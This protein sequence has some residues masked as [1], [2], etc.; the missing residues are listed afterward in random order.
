MEQD[1][2]PSLYVNEHSFHGQFASREDTIAAIHRLW[3][4]NRVCREYSAQCL[5]S[6]E[7]LGL[8]SALSDTTLREVVV[9]YPNPD[10]RKLVL[11]WLDKH[12]PF[13]DAN[14]RH[15]ADDWYFA[16]HGSEELLATGSALAECARQVLA[17]ENAAL[18]SAT[19]SDFTYTPVQAGILNDDGTRD[20]CELSNHWSEPPLR[21]Y[22]EN[23]IRL[24]SWLELRDHAKQRFANLVF[25]AD[26]FEPMMKSPFSL[27]LC[28]RITSLLANLDQLSGEMDARTGALSPAGEILRQSFFEGRNALFSDSSDSEKAAFKSALT[29]RCPVNQDMRLFSWHGKARGTDQYRVHFGWP[30]SNPARGLPIVY[31]GPKIT[32]R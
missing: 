22:L 10:T 1:V 28:Q 30:K 5:C 21:Q 24:G 15:D 16:A 14:R 9:Q 7:L 26:T 19:P 13:W 20:Q 12:G 18:L 29:F 32:K 4:L 11:N 6:R 31:I 8:R 27:A 3:I 23:T 25:A 2:T 17:E